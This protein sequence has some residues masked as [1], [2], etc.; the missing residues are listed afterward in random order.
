MNFKLQIKASDKERKLTLADDK[1][2]CSE[3]V[4]VLADK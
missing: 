3:P 4:P 1:M 2:C